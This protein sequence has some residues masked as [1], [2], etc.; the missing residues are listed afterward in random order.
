VENFWENVGK[1]SMEH[2]ADIFTEYPYDS[3]YGDILE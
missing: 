1:Y 3:P 2:L